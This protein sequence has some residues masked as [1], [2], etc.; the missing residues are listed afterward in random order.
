[1]RWIATFLFIAAAACGKS[2]KTGDATVEL[3][4]LDGRQDSVFRKLITLTNNT[5]AENIQDD[6]LAF[7]ILP[8]EAS[9]ASCRKK[10]IDSIVIHSRK[11]LDR[12][13][14]IISAKAGRKKINSYFLEENAELS[15]IENRLFLDS[16]NSA[17]KDSLCFDRPTIYYT[18][19]RKAYKKV[20]AIPATVRQNLRNFFQ[21]TEHEEK[22]N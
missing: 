19:N 12:R 10:T 17:A 18:F 5:I 6:S 11:L 9:C 20:A 21:G 13:Y 22:E 2:G 3:I 16:I 1:M 8:I 14:I 4:T 15:A 7:L